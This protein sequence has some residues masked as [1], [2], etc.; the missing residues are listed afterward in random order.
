MF[1][2]AGGHPGYSL[3]LFINYFLHS[4]TILFPSNQCRQRY[5]TQSWGSEWV[6][7][8]LPRPFPAGRGDTWGLGCRWWK[9]VWETKRQTD[10]M[11][12][13]LPSG[14]RHTWSPPVLLS[15][16]STWDN[17]L[18]FLHKPLWVGFEKEWWLIYV[19]WKDCTYR[20]ED[21]LPPKK[22]RL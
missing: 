22:R 6:P 4:Q 10:M 20:R 2:K 5:V 16:L 21:I 3:R 19:Y 14:S 18:L 15:V 9:P 8:L 7:G 12:S 11:T 13:L 17:K 1:L